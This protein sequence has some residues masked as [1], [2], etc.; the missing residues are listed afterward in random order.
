M[1]DAQGSFAKSDE[2][3]RFPSCRF[4]LKKR[5]DEPAQFKIRLQFGRA[6]QPVRTTPQL[7]FQHK[8]Q[9]MVSPTRMVMPRMK[10]LEVHE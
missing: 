10:V 3:K 8:D 4:C 5:L 1:N 7:G 2:E 9:G 6:R